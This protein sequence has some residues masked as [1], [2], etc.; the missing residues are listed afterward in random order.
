MVETS[1]AYELSTWI[2][3][4]GEKSPVV[5]IHT[6]V[7]LGWQVRWWRITFKA[8][9]YDREGVVGESSGGLYNFNKMHRFSR[10]PVS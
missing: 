7:A 4:F 3:L 1:A 8:K 5:S 6:A 9:A 2:A 10:P